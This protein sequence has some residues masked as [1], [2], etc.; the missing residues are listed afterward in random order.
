MSTIA[1]WRSDNEVLVSG[2]IKGMLKKCVNFGLGACIRRK[3]IRYVIL[4]ILVFKKILMILMEIYE[5]N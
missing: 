4:D 2:R 5:N 3:N 1:F